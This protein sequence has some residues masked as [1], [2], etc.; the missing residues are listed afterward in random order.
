MIKIIFQTGLLELISISEIIGG[1]IATLFAVLSWWLINRLTERKEWKTLTENMN[2]LYEILQAEK[3]YPNMSIDL[4][5]VLVEDIEEY[6]VMKYLK[7]RYYVQN[8]IHYFE[9]NDFQIE[10]VTAIGGP[11]VELKQ[12]GKEIFNYYR[13]MEGEETKQS[14]LNFIESNCRKAGI[15]L[16]TK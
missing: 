8:G 12:Y 15:K 1:V 10:A 16:K 13:P 4:V 6:N 11:K 2:E 3:Y 5:R 9:G 14:F 7:L